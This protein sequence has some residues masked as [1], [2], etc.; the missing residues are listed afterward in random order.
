TDH[1]FY[2]RGRELGATNLLVYGPAGRLHEVIDVRV[3]FDAAALQNDLEKALPGE[4][5]RVSTLGEGLLLSGQVSSTAVVNKAKALAE[6]FAPQGVT[7]ALTALA[8][9]QV[10][11]EVRVLEANRSALQDLGFMATI[12]NSSFDFSYGNGLVSNSTPTGVLTLTGGAGRTSIDVQLRALEEKGIVRTL[13][14]PNLVAVSGEKA[15]FLAGG[16]FPFPVPNGIDRVTIEFRPYGVKLNFQP[17]VQDNGLIKL[18]VEPEVSALDPTNSLRLANITIPALTVRRANTTVELKSGDSL[19][20][21]GLFQREYANGVKQL[22]GLG[23]VPVLSALFR[24]TR[25]KRAE[26]ELIIVVTPRLATAEDIAAA[27][28]ANVAG[29]EPSVADLLLNGKAHDRPLSRADDP[30]AR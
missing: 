16:E 29:D 27:R 14:K 12:R 4:T 20:I 28:A 23:E 10:V 7:S 26:T 8:T 24:S 3:G 22:P 19:A 6:K 17:V 13:A 18:Q 21:G 11:L 5:I 30:R 2:V 1:S 15:S 25:W 9:E